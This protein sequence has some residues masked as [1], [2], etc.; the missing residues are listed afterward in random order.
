MGKTKMECY[1]VPYQPGK[2]V[3]TSAKMNSHNGSSLTL[4]RKY[5]VQ[6]SFIK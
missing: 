2:T 5:A 1:S 4:S 3:Q 6:R